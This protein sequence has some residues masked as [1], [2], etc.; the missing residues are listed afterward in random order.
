MDDLSVLLPEQRYT[1]SGSGYL[2]TEPFSGDIT[3]VLALDFDGI[4]NLEDLC[5]KGFTIH[6][7]GKKD[8]V[9]IFGDYGEESIDVSEALDGSTVY[10]RLNVPE[11]FPNLTMSPQEAMARY[12]FN[13]IAR[14]GEA[15]GHGTEQSCSGSYLFFYDP[16][17]PD[18]SDITVEYSYKA[19]PTDIIVDKNYKTVYVGVPINIYR[20]KLYTISPDGTKT[21]VMYDQFRVIDGTD[22]PQRIGD[23]VAKVELG[24][25]ETSGSGDPVFVN[26]WEYTDPF[27]DVYVMTNFI[28]D[29]TV[30]AI[31]NIRSISGEYVGEPKT[32]KLNTADN[33]II[34]P[35][36]L[37]ITVELFQPME[38]RINPYTL[39]PEEFIY[40][41]GTIKGPVTKIKVTYNSGYEIV[42]CIVEVLADFEIK[43]ILAWYEGPD[44]LVGRSYAPEN[45]I[46]Y[47]INNYDQWIRVSVDKADNDDTPMSQHHTLTIIPTDQPY[48]IN[49]VG[50]NWF[51]IKF[52]M[53]GMELSDIFNVTGIQEDV[54]IDKD[55]KIRYIR[56]KTTWYYL[57]VTE[58]FLPYLGMEDIVYMSWK[59]FLEAC[60]DYGYYGLFEVILP[61]N[62]GMNKRYT[63]R[64][65]AWARNWKT[66]RAHCV[67]VYR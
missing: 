53:S 43:Q 7:P 23:H 21:E 41:P 59:Q 26:T 20:L 66:I 64:W 15:C 55:V 29:I 42:E 10:V 14:T 11:E 30:E 9:V 40:D 2:N 1:L 44:I 22:V 62:T 50:D 46:V 38:G 56:S 18:N 57:D 4:E 27:G 17:R 58:Q 28:D 12:V 6:N 52:N 51:R 65:F 45:V 61:P 25:Y 47:L 31:S 32:V 39:L 33:S 5:H 8:Y 34:K 54:V 67:E 37:E 60:S 36:D 19:L 35:E 3:N 16:T 63:T 49:K 48:R 13:Q 24:H